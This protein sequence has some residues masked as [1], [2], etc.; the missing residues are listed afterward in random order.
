[1]GFIL[2]Y[3]RLGTNPQAA[4]A[5]VEPQNLPYAILS[6]GYVGRPNSVSF[7]SRC[8]QNADGTGSRCS[9]GQVR[10][11]RFFPAGMPCERYL[12][13]VSFR[14]FDKSLPCPVRRVRALPLSAPRS[15]VYGN[16]E[17]QLKWPLWL[18]FAVT[19]PV[20]EVPLFSA[21]YEASLLNPYLFAFMF[22][23][24]YA[25]NHLA[26]TSTSNP[27]IMA[28]RCIILFVLFFSLNTWGIKSPTAM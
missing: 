17:G 21:Q 14:V 23:H 25:A 27:R 9:C 15:G 5:D 18:R 6:A 2:F 10:N 12:R 4:P 19:S 26:E 28:K 22:L 1:M 3:C 20:L 7:R 16:D 13:R 24:N 8:R 11:A